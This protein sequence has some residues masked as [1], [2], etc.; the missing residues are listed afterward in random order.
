MLETTQGWDAYNVTEDADLSFRIA[1][2]GG[3]IG[4]IRTGTDEE[5]VGNMRD[6]HFQRARWIKGYLQSWGVHMR[7]PLLPGGRM[8]LA[9]FFTLQITL[10]LT[11]LA[12]GFYAP[13]VIILGLY[14]GVCAISGTAINIP[15]IYVASFGFSIAVGIAISALGVFRAG[16][17]YLI[18]SALYVPAY[19]LLLFWPGL[20]A[21]WELRRMPFHWHKTPHGV[22]APDDDDPQ[23]FEYEPLT[24]EPAE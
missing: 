17:P 6:W 24:H 13:S 7:A 5:A 19:W 16:K 14:L 22:S 21:I 3:K 4:Y 10:G 11:L 20:R 23:T 15:L 9:R 2:H 18:K 1:A 8:G 12:I